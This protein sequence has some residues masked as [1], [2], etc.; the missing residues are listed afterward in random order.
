MAAGKQARH[1]TNAARSRLRNS[2]LRAVDEL[3]DVFRSLR[4]RRVTL[5]DDR[6]D[7]VY[8]LADAAGRLVGALVHFCT[9]LFR[10]GHHDYAGNRAGNDTNRHSFDKRHVLIPSLIIFCEVK[11][12][13]VI[14]SQNG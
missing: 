13:C 12:F 14:I 1:T 7:A 5:Y 4:G 11:D 9:A 3:S 10:F 2:R 6:Y 8:Q